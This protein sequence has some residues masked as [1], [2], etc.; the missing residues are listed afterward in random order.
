ME[1]SKI[2]KEYVELE[3][4]AWLRDL[5]NDLSTVSHSSP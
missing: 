1:E 4:S 2:L 3:G 5:I